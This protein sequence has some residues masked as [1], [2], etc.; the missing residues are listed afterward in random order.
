MVSHNHIQSYENPSFKKIDTNSANMDGAA[1]S[2]DINII[3]VRSWL[4]SFLCSYIEP[5]RWC[6]VKESYPSRVE[7]ARITLVL[8]GVVACDMVAKS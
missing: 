6:W 4:S 5:W 1:R 7:K 8:C 2:D 3:D